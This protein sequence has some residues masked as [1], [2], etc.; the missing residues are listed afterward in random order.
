M[1]Q[2]Q[3]LSSGALQRA[4]IQATND[5]ALTDAPLARVLRDS[6]AVEN[7]HHDGQ[8]WMEVSIEIYDP[9]KVDR[10][11]QP[12]ARSQKNVDATS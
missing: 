4:E 6:L 11:P 8:H 5:D 12:A 3:P 1:Q 2:P 7:T 9:R 10:P